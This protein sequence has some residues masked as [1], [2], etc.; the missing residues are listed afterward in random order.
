MLSEMGDG[1]EKIHSE[2][3]KFKKIKSVMCV[4]L[5]SRSKIQG[6]IYVDSVSRLYGFRK[7][8]LSLI[9]ALS[10]PAAMAIENALLYSNLEKNVEARTKDLF[11]T[12][13]S[14]R[15][16]ESRFRA[17]FENMTSG[18]GVYEG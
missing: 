2:S 13:E 15:A 7:E 17:I 3:M 6:V 16:S 11:E 1:S 12:K 10:S 14:L 4:P 9:A 18:V 8:D 5:L